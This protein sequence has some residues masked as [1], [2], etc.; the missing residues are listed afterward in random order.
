MVR[1]A[2]TAARLEPR[3]PG[4]RRH[5]S[6]EWIA[7][8]CPSRQPSRLDFADQSQDRLGQAVVRA[9]EPK[10]RGWI[11]AALD[12]GCMRAM[13][14]GVAEQLLELLA[15]R[16]Q[17]R[18]VELRPGEQQRRLGTQDAGKRRPLVIFAGV[19]AKVGLFGR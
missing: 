19:R 1:S 10:H 15:L 11:V 6:T 2:A 13:G 8:A 5:G 3:G 16:D 4:T 12:H 14:D 17:G 18:W 9:V 7:L